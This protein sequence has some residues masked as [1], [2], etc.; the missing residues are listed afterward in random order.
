MRAMG[1]HFDGSFHK[2]DPGAFSFAHLRPDRRQQGDSDHLISLLVGWLKM[3]SS[4]F[5][6]LL[7]MAIM[8]AQS[9]SMSRNPYADF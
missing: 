9:D 7:F 5:L 8:T 6:F 3:F 2:S 4:V 1:R